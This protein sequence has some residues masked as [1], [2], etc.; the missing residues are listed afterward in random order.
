MTAKVET[1]L[2]LDRTRMEKAGWHGLAR[3]AGLFILFLLCAVAAFV[4]G[5][6]YYSIFPTNKNVFYEGGLAAAFLIAALLLRRWSRN[7]PYWQVAY[8]FFVA[9][10]VFL[11]TSLTAGFRD[12]LFQSVGI[13]AGTNQEAAAGKVFEA[14]VT[15]TTILLLSR[16][17]GMR[18]ESLYV[19]RGNLKWGLILG[20]GLVINFASSSL[21]FFAGR[22]TGPEKLGPVILWGLVFSFANGFMEELWLRGQFLRKLQPLLGTGTAIV[23][24]SLWWALFHLGSVYMMPAAIPFY[25]ANLFTFG[26]AYGYAMHKTGSWIA[27]GLMH[28]ASDFFLFVAMLSSA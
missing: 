11:V 8:A 5:S 26:L 6:N 13:A 22:F 9:E 19:Q 17:A 4:F 27:P 28:A 16:L 15:I 2:L 14:L 21:M 24:T 18:L 1:D 3:K 12:G 10:F 20:F 7:R 25:L 23:L